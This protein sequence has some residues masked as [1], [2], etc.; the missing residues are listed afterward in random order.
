MKK[1]YYYLCADLH[2]YQVGTISI[3]PNVDALGEM[4]ATNEMIIKQYVVGTGGA[5]K[6]PYDGD[7]IR[8]FSESK[9]IIADKVTTS[10]NMTDEDIANSKSVNGFLNCI[11][12]GDGLNFE[13]IEATES[14]PES[15]TESIPE[16]I[17]ESVPESAIAPE[18]AT[19]ESAMG[20]NKRT[21]KRARRNTRRNT[22]KNTRK[23]TMKKSRRSKRAK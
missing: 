5:E 13:F 21:R 20:G 23:N 8:E 1:S 14:M 2:Q 9:S 4:S 17:P 6:D 15:A 12:N 19:T 16:S 18:S 10:Y 11:E 22:R 3:K 7:K